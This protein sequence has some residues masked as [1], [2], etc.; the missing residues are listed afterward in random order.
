M[1]NQNETKIC[2]GQAHRR[3]KLFII[4]IVVTQQDSEILLAVTWKIVTIAKTANY[5]TVNLKGI[6]SVWL[7]VQYRYRHGQ[8]ERHCVAVC[9]VP[10]RPMTV[11]PLLSFVSAMLYGG[12]MRTV[13][14][15]KP[16]IH[17]H[18]LIFLVLSPMPMVSM[19][20]F[21]EEAFSFKLYETSVHHVLC[22]LVAKFLYT[23]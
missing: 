15:A 1:R 21:P 5:C 23:K 18:L 17:F 11:A 6:V 22:R 7:F 13:R 16:N 20:L 14:T 8:S 9:T 2:Q 4:I 12:L 10:A 19:L 3:G